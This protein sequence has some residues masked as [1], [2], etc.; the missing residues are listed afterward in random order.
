MHLTSYGATYSGADWVNVL[1]AGGAVSS[2][3]FLLFIVG[4]FVVHYMFMGKNASKRNSKL[5]K[6]LCF[7]KFMIRK[8]IQIF[9]LICVVA[10]AAVTLFIVIMCATTGFSG[11]LVGL[12]SGA[13]FFCVSQLINRLIF[14]QV[15]LMVSI[16]TDVKDLR[17]HF[18]G[19][20]QAT[21]APVA[22]PVVNAA[23]EPKPVAA[24]PASNATSAAD[25]WD[26]SCGKTENTG[27]FCAKCGSPRP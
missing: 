27:K 4:C 25:S 13:V 18:I 12:I 11:F 8:V 7:D 24:K 10:I 1:F 5:G 9:N 17:N 14:E 23:P 26:C 19:G 22:A 2:I 15:M 16:T 3:C 21:Q 20:A 6:L